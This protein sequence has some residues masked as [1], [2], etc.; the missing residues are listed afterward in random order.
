MQS[1][2]HI[3]VGI[4]ADTLQDEATVTGRPRPFSYSNLRDTTYDRQEYACSEGRL[5]I[6]NDIAASRAGRAGSSK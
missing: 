1:A 3:G 4:G 2:F 6:E 5:A